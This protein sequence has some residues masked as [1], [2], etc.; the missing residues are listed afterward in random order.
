MSGCLQ[1]PLVH[2]GCERRALVP[3]GAAAP[4]QPGSEGVHPG[5]RHRPLRLYPG[6]LVRGIFQRGNQP[7]EVSIIGRRGPLAYFCV[8]LGRL[9]LVL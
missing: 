5:R 4:R 7:V 9:F 2:D 1:R 6:P 8:L 3:Q